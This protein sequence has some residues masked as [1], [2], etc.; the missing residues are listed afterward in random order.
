MPSLEIYKASAGSGKTFRIVREYLRMVFQRPSSYKNIL[1]VTFTNK[2]T[3]EMKDRILNDLS[4]LATGKSSGH[5]E[6]LKAEFRQSEEQIR[7]LASQILKLILHDYSRF[8]VTTIDS[9]FQRVIKAFS[10]EMRLNSS[11]RTELDVQ[12]VLEEAVDRL[13]MEIDS[14]EGL[15]TWM[16]EYAGEN[17]KDGKNW[18]FR[19]DLTSRGKEL[20]KEEFKQFSE[21]L[22]QKLQDKGFLTRYSRQL[23]KLSDDYKQKLIGIGNQALALIAANGLTTEKFK[24][25]KGS[26]ASHFNKLSAGDL[27][28]P[29]TRTTGACNNL[30]SWYKAGDSDVLK[31]QIQI[32]YTA[33]LN[34]LLV[35]SIE[36]MNTEGILANTAD[37][38][39]SNLFSFGLLTDIALKVQE[40][41]KEKNIVLLND[42][43]Q[44]LSKVI[45]GSD[46]PFVYEKMGSVFRNFML[47]EF[48][49]TSRLQWQNFKPLIENSLSEGNRNIIVGDVKQSI[50]RWRNGD[51]NLLATEVEKDLAAFGSTVVALDTN[52]RSAKNVVDF[53]NSMFRES[54]RLLNND[55]ESAL[56]SSG[57]SFEEFPG[58]K[59][60]IEQAYSDHYQ[61]Y[62]GKVQQDGYVRVQFIESDDTQK[63]G[64][65]RDL[66]VGEL[67]AQ[68]ELAQERGVR[69][70]EIA[71]LVRDKRDGSIVAKALLEKKYASPDTH[72]CYDV[73]SNDTL[74]IG[75]SPV[76]KFILNLFKLFSKGPNDI[77]KSDLIY[78]YFNYLQPLISGANQEVKS[79][80]LHSWFNIP[81][82]VPEL[83]KPWFRES[84]DVNFDQSYLSLP[85]FELTCRIAS[86][87]ELHRIAG[88]LVYLEAFMDLILQ[89]G[90]DEAGGI[91]GFLNWWETSGSNKTITLS[92]GRDA[93][94]IYT[95]HKAKGLE[96][97]TVLVPFCD[98]EI[99][100]KSN[101]VQYLW[102]H[103]DT[104]PF[105]QMDLVLVKYGSALQQ[106]LFSG[107]YFREM[108]YSSVDNLNLLYVALTRAVN[109][110]IVFCP[111]SSKLTSPNKSISSLIQSV[112]ENL[113]LMDS[114]DRTKYINLNELW[115]P[116]TKIFELGDLRKVI[117]STLSDTSNNRLLDHF[118][119]TGREEHLNLRI[120]RETYVDLYDSLQS[121]KVSHGNL[122]HELF[123]KIDTIG[124]VPSSIKKVLSEG[125]IDTP[126]ALEYERLIF[127][128]LEKE[129]FKSWFSGEWRV[130]NERDILRGKEQRHRPDRVMIRGNELVVVD[131]KTGVRSNSHGLQVRGYLRD[132]V[133]M[134]YLNPRGYLWYLSENELVEVS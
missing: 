86:D 27:K 103:P 122:M 126:T 79:G 17:L 97:H 113:P 52:W 128:V 3:A 4:S 73:I 47:D 77:V 2:A 11:Y 59:G 42:S 58:M 15:R 49:D 134:G 61:K 33:G 31:Q 80:Q 88:E 106:S 70:G 48:Q 85:L 98:W 84:E 28:L 76:V 89:Y 118:I 120:R 94:S 38:I 123:E 55:F 10:R 81:A 53:N 50:Y 111:Y 101:K 34:S 35:T 92:E 9:F 24:F 125:K 119:L 67:I 95:I 102:C 19:D 87:F 91:S 22:L 54:S 63:K 117:H 124:N 96:F 13:F 64:E 90:R 5:L 18:N 44:L 37:A 121:E 7:T 72:Y 115:N 1:A 68:I 62:S 93:I 25:G 8:S 23:H 112:I 45:S 131:Y 32:I 56:S 40:V 69:P 83:F 129:P 132:F 116:E 16:L 43:A 130:L 105:N 107:A 75:L 30:E 21:P 51:W 109:S 57:H 12:L 39:L 66:A 110:L 108:L 14:N 20:F 104:V 114:I 100:P 26:F 36:I 99:A 127:L 46:S 78:S 60:I 6:Y 65:F 71:V 41:S 133:K 82:E 74:V 29:G